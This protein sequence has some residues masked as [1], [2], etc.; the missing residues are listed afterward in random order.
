MNTYWIGT[1][2][3][4]STLATSRHVLKSIIILLVTA[5]FYLV[6]SSNNSITNNALKGATLFV[7]IKKA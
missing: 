1:I 4:D 7:H 3:Y 5:G 6:N 2:K